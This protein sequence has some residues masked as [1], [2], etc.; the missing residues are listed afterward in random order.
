MKFFQRFSRRQRRSSKSVTKHRQPRFGARLRLESLEQ[1]ALLDGFG[2]FSPGPAT[3]FALEAPRNVIAGSP[4]QLEVVALDASN[5][6]VPSYTGTVTLTST[7]PTT[8]TGAD[9]LPG[10]Y[11]FSSSDHGMHRFSITLGTANVAD[12]ITATDGATPPDSGQITI[13]PAAA[14]VATHFGVYAAENTTVGTPTTVLVVALDA[15]NHPVTNYTGAVTL[16][17]TTD[18]SSANPVQPVTYTFQAGDHGHHALQMTFNSTGQKTLNVSDTATP[19]DTG[20]ITINVNP[21]PVV[22]HFGVYAAENTTV[23]RPT[24]VWVVPLDA[25]NHPVAN[26]TGTVSLTTNDTGAT[27]TGPTTGS[28]GYFQFQVTFQTTGPITLTASDNATPTPDTGTSVINVNPAPVATQLLIITPRH[29]VAGV[30][31]PVVVV[32]L[33]ASNHPVPDYTGT[34]TLADTAAGISS[35]YTYQGSDRGIHVFM[36]TFPTTA[37]GSQT[38]SASDGTLTGTA[39]VNVLAP[40]TTSRVTGGSISIPGITGGSAMS[41]GSHYTAVASS[42]WRGWR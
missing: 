1:R 10:P 15:S 14:P 32:A 12:T 17:D 24:T 31:E 34:V 2:F 4:T 38:L 22:T 8:G 16:T 11:N 9:V 36:V 29:V 25:A 13:S 41:G 21:A 28:H 42:H 27:V 20:T 26:Y 39:S 30:Q 33:D 19:A 7:G 18:A 6:L 3:H 35:Q 37:T 5:H 23:G 40:P